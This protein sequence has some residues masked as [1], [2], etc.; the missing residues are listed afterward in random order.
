LCKRLFYENG[1]QQHIF[2][3]V[4]WVIGSPNLY[5]NLVNSIRFMIINTLFILR[6]NRY[7]L[8]AVF[9]GCLLSIQ[10][11][12]QDSSHKKVL[13]VGNS[14]TYFWNLPQTVGAMSQHGN[15]KLNVEQSTAGGVNLAQHWRSEKG[16]K[17]RQLLED[18]TYDIII[19]QDHSLRSIEA[20]DSLHYYG[21]K[22]IDLAQ[23]KG[24]EVYLYMTWSRSWNPFMI[25]TIAREYEKLAEATG[26]NLVPVGLAWDKSTRLRPDLDLYDPDDTHPSPEGTYLS[27][28]MFYGA[29]TGQSPR[30]LPKRVVSKDDRGQK[31]YWNIQSEENA[32]FFQE[33]AHQTLTSQKG[34]H[35]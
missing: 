23:S 29:L 6:R 28:C 9:I 25:E 2:G 26:V 24:A 18:N 15:Q 33:V 10:L 34:D 17:T 3:P 19:F 16:L 7:T 35:D 5:V 27:A 30:G 32:T 20:P 13:F 21:E 22:F 14:Y 4:I 8:W 11:S 1:F 12:A 31:L